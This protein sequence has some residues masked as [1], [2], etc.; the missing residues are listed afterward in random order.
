MLGV[1]RFC[2]EEGVGIFNSR[3]FDYTDFVDV[4]RS[5]YSPLA[6]LIRETTHQ[7][8]VP[9]VI[10]G[11]G[12]RCMYKTEFLKQLFTKDQLAALVSECEANQLNIRYGRVRPNT[13]TYEDAHQVVVPLASIY[14]MK[15]GVGDISGL[16]MHI[17]KY[18]KSAARP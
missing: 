3:L 5:E 1:V 2:D 15:H 8:R 14:R 6:T 18:G 16:L 7:V 4:Y 17:D 12:H 13:P 10:W 11:G 9:S